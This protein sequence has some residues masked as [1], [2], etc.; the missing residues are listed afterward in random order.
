MSYIDEIVRLGLRCNF[1]CLFCNIT[2]ENELGI[3][4]VDLKE[5]MRMVD[6]AISRGNKTIS[7]S[8]GEPTL[9]NYL[10][11]LV[12]YTHE[13][14]VEVR[15]QTNASL[16]TQELAE[17]LKRAGLD[18]AFINFVSHRPELF[19]K[20]TGVPRKL[21][22]KTVEGIIAFE[23][24][25]V[26]VTLNIVINELNYREL[27]EYVKY[28]AE[29]FPK[30]KI[31]VLSVI[32]PHGRAF[33]NRDLVPDYRK[34]EPYIESARTIAVEQGIFV[35]NPF[36]GLPLCMASK[37]APEENSEFLTGKLIR[38]GKR[39][40]DPLVRVQTSKLRPPG[41]RDC[42]LRSFCLGV[43]KKYYEIKGDV[44]EPPH[45]SLRFW[46]TG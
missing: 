16:V 43:W 32:Q 13:R 29:N 45:R 33:L 30:I 24:A 9:K 28:V 37:M 19:S 7:I 15:L 3:I 12:K 17:Q 34:L 35:S 2:P 23:K 8:G 27:P 40:L 1:N 4:E 20:L 6:H 42:Y 22:E 25:G 11:E 31:I 18:L 44:V 5:A 46:P 38:S 26:P 21:F 14:G 41:C 10:V 36:C 39:V